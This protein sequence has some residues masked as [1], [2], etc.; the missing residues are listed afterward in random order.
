MDAVG[1]RAAWRSAAGDLT[2]GIG[3]SGADDNASR[4]A[5]RSPIRP[6]RAHGAS[7]GGITGMLLHFDGNF[8]P[9]IEG[10]TATV[11]ALL[12]MIA[13]DPR[14]H[15]CMELLRRPLRQRAA[16]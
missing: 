6:H 4:S 10:P 3:D 13:R 2:D 8:E 11:E 9:V 15:G 7:F 16:Q 1:G 12:A 14:H 5:L